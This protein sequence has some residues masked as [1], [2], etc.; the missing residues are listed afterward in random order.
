[1]ASWLAR[2]ALRQ[3]GAPQQTDWDALQR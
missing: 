1:M 3:F 2:E